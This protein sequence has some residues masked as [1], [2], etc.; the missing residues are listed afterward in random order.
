MLYFPV[1]HYGAGEAALFTALPDQ[2]GAVTLPSE[3]VFSL[4]AV[5]ASNVPRLLVVVGQVFV[6]F[7]QRVLAVGA[8]D[9]VS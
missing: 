3:K 5:A 9:K 4:V 7:Q 1:H 6:I 2:E 8:G